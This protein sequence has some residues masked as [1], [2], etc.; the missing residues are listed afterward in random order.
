MF[1]VGS[2]SVQGTL[3]RSRG[4]LIQRGREKKGSTTASLLEDAKVTLRPEKRE[5]WTR[6]KGWLWGQVCAEPCAHEEHDEMREERG[7]AC[8]CSVAGG[9]G[10]DAAGEGGG[11][12]GGGRGTGA[13]GSMRR[14]LHLISRAMG[15]KENLGWGSNV[16]D[17]LTRLAK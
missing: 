16:P 15:S 17:V 4:Q 2:C 11:G 5:G 7:G 9:S 10:C 14:I 3:S 12:R 13:S 1:V 6:R 8:G